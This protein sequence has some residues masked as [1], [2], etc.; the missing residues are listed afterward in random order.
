M[1]NSLIGVARPSRVSLDYG[2]DTIGLWIVSR[3][4]SMSAS[5]VMAGTTISA[6]RTDIAAVSAV[7]TAGAAVAV[8]PAPADF[9][10]EDYGAAGDGAADDTVAFA[11]M[12]AAINALPGGRAAITLGAGKTYRVGQQTLAGNTTSNGSW[13]PAPIL[14]LLDMSTLIINGNGAV[15]KVNDGLRAGTFDPITGAPTGT[16]D[17][18]IAS[19]AGN[20][21]YVAGPGHVIE[22]YNVD[23]VAIRDLTIDGNDAAMVKA[24]GIGNAGSADYSVPGSGVIVQR[25]DT[26]IVDNCNIHHCL[27]DG[28][29]FYDNGTTLNTEGHRITISASNFSYAGRN[30]VFFGG[31]SNI[32]VHSSKFNHVGRGAFYTGPGSGIDFEAYYPYRARNTI[33]ESCEFIDN[34][35]RAYS[36]A[37][38]FGKLTLKRCLFRTS[39]SL[40]I[41][42][43]ARGPDVT[44]EDC[45]F[46][47]LL[48]YYGSDT[49]DPDS[50]LK[51]DTGT[52]FWRC[53]FEDTD[54]IAPVAFL[55][56]AGLPTVQ[57][58]AMQR[59]G[60]ST[61]TTVVTILN[62]T[63]ASRWRIQIQYN[64]TLVEDFDNLNTVGGALGTLNTS[65]YAVFTDLGST[66]TNPTGQPTPIA[67]VT[68][69][70]TVLDRSLGALVCNPT[71]NVRFEDCTFIPHRLM[72]FN[73]SSS[74]LQRPTILRRC[75]VVVYNDSLADKGAQAVLRS[76]YLD[77]LTFTEP[78]GITPPTT[79]WYLSAF[80][81]VTL[82][83]GGVTVG[84]LIHWTAF[85]GR[86][87]AIRN[88]QTPRMWGPFVPSVA[89]SQGD[90]V[91]NSSHL[92]AAV[93]NFTAGSGFVGTDWTQ[94][95]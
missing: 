6:F 42:Y 48:N 29:E 52:Q 63:L 77:G 45:T 34:R 47:G 65:A 41:V 50:V 18:A 75:T 35:S 57:A 83:P 89:Y 10:P 19:T 12:A 62:G 67:N 71:E 2:D 56:H 37:E 95:I 61:A 79:G 4:T 46:Y 86:T 22:L 15:I 94:L 16:V 70:V 92:Y 21:K 49:Y 88:P 72:A 90:L 7:I 5:T 93:T 68:L 11:A 55:D 39:G 40:G 81:T 24:G 20:Q 27:L 80:P 76:A 43:A 28:L 44:H 38:G 91:T 33:V 23:T 73:F 58:E 26:L 51:P 82:G 9:S 8:R 1:L 69:P 32:H 78:P 13:L 3:A 59:Y 36:A 54:Y 87:G 85:N 14:K 64:G 74:T 30:A 60:A 84:P 31:S 25:G 53:H 17:V 66:S